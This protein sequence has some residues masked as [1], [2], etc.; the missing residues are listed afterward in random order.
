MDIARPGS[1]DVLMLFA[2]AF[3]GKSLDALP[4][5]WWWLV[6]LGVAV[7]LPTILLKNVVTSRLAARRGAERQ[8]WL[9]SGRG[10]WIRWKWEA[11]DFAVGALILAPGVLLSLIIYDLL[12]P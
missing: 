2:G 12:V 1:R 3:L 5:N 10:G 11:M 7:L 6:V 8:E 9:G 4:T